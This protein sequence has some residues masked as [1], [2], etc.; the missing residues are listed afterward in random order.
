M[1]KLA[2]IGHGRMGQL[3]QRLAPDSGCQVV[4]IFDSQHPFQPQPGIDVAIEFTT[5]ESAPRNLR[6]LIQARIPTVTGTT[7]WFHHLPDIESLVHHHQSAL[8]WA[9]NFSI[10]VNVFR[11][12]TAEAARLLARHDAYGAY[13]WEV[14]HQAKLDAPSGT[15]LSLAQSMRDAGFPRPV[16]LAS[17]RAGHH[18]GTHEITFD[19]PED[20]IALRHTAR[21]REGFARGALL[22][23]H[24]ISQRQGCFEFSQLLFEE[25]S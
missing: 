17:N 15:L 6:L 5:P 22:A 10:G 19:S 7:G 9:S 8:V 4:S 12:V 24:L 25:E 13:G 21:S 20:T 1:L 2:L 18:P 23:A 11:R 14:H 3:I 16:H